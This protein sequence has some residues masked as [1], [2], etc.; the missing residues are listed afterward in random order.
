MTDPNHDPE[1][2]TDEQDDPAFTALLKRSLGG[3][4]AGEGGG[5]PPPVDEGALLEGVQAKL[6]KRSRGKF[7]GDG[8]STNRSHVSYAVVAALMLVT[9]V[10][11]YVALG[12]T[13]IR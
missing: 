13:G 7:Y 10:V 12:P 9:I 2:P 5:E 3:P 11:V 8:W 1:A 6:R 4:E